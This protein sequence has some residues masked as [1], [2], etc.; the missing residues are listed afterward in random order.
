MAKRLIPRFDILPAPQQRLWTEL[1]TVPAA[2]VLYGG[3]AIALHL[4]HRQ[5]EDFDFFADSEIDVA[6][7]YGTLPFLRGAQITQQEPNTLTC[8]VDR[9]G[10]VKVS[11]FGLPKLK[12][13]RASYAVT[14]HTLKIADLLDLAG[15]KAAVVQQRAQ[16]KDYID[17]DAI[18]RQG[19]IDLPFHLAAARLIFGDEFAPTPTLKAITYFDDGD[20]AMLPAAVKRR[21]TAAAAAVDPLRLPHL[22]RTASR[23]NPKSHDTP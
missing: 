3:T 8:L 2:F 11:F 20:L 13:I 9:G 15:C 7:L 19:K 4:G 16:R 22:K 12:R 14:G 1:K 10:P 18:I 5:S 6:A 17:I 21:L 23:R